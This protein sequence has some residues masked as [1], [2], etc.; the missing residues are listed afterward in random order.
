M[1]KRQDKIAINK[2]EQ[3][4]FLRGKE[5]KEIEDRWERS[6]IHAATMQS[7]LD[8]VVEQYNEHRDELDPDVV[9]K[10]EEQIALR[11]AE[12]KDYLMSEQAICA[13]LLEEYSKAN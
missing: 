3:K 2:A 13:Q 11:T 10:T 4:D 5:R 1:S 8:Y 12:I 7:V 6:Q 9:A